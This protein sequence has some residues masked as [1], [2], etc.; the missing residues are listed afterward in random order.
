MA[1]MP[2]TSGQ[3]SNQVNMAVRLA[4]A[5]KMID[6]NYDFHDLIIALENEDL[7]SFKQAQFKA[8]AKG[9]WQLLAG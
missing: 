8:S 9:S 3:I 2:Q 1:D 7:I 5:G 4:V 6:R